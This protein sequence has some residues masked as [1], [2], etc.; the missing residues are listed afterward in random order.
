MTLPAVTEQTTIQPLEEKL[1][2]LELQ[3]QSLEQFRKIAQAQE[4]TLV[5]KSTQIIELSF[6]VKRLGD[7]IAVYKER[8][9]EMTAA[10]HTVA[11]DSKEDLV[12]TAQ[13]RQLGKAMFANKQVNMHFDS[14]TRKLVY[15]ETDTE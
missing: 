8:I 2:N 10:L 4:V 13:S 14:L 5:E 7:T 15:L 3:V 12:F 9:K 11:T 1:I 6:E